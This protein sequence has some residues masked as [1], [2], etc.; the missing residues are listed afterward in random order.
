MKSEWW[1]EIERSFDLNTA[2]RPVIAHGVVLV[3]IGYFI[4]SRA[5]PTSGDHSIPGELASAL[6]ELWDSSC[7]EMEACVER[8]ILR[9]KAPL[10]GSL[11]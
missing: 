5:L 7:K 6:R 3:A 11:N 9:G 1:L 2:A 4:A 8:H 10:D